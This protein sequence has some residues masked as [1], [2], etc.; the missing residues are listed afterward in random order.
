MADRRGHPGWAVAILAGLLVGCG[1]TPTITETPSGTVPPSILPSLAAST[2]APSP[3]ESTTPRPTPLPTPGP[4]EPAPDSL[5]AS[6][7]VER[8]GTRITVSIGASP[9]QAGNRMTVQTSIENTGRDTLHW[10]VD[11]CG[12]D[13]RVRGELT[14][15]AWRPS[16][17]AV[18][19]IVWGYR[20]WL[21]E[22]AQV[23]SSIRLEFLP[24]SLSGRRSFGCA[25][26][27][28]TRSLKPGKSRTDEL[29]WDG[30]AAGRLGLPPTSPTVITA[31]FGNWYRGDSEEHPRKPIVATLDTWVVGGRNP[32]YLSA[33]EAID[34][35]LRDPAFA[36]WL[37]T[38]PFRTGDDAVVEY[39]Q[40]VGVWIVGLFRSRYGSE[41]VLHAALVDPVTGEVIAI[42]EHEVR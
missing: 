38:Q 5:P 13:V 27:G 31:T 42:R 14:G 24:S 35:A 2:A 12:I 4:S 7:T 17:L 10:G 33:A 18:E 20:E 6:A 34:A 1:V 28:I 3:V 32:A 21:R 22:Q 9:I 40:E 23:D 8:D 26:L 11:G 29:V 30:Q 41:P 37:V 19:P 36:D 16:S 25:D 39:D 15:A